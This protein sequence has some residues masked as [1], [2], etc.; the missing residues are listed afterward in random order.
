MGHPWNRVVYTTIMA[1]MVLRPPHPRRRTRHLENHRQ[2][3]WKRPTV[4]H[5]LLREIKKYRRLRKEA[6][7]R[8]G[9]VVAAEVEDESVDLTV[10]SLSTIVDDLMPAAADKH[11]GTREAW[12]AAIRKC[13]W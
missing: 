6:A 5:L 12:I 3:V 2:A 9:A 7:G 13:P 11:G 10:E 8:G 4:L 1:C